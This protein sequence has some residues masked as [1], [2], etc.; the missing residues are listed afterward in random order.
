MGLPEI[1][2]L[3]LLL[4]L[5]CVTYVCYRLYKENK[6]DKWR[7][8]KYEKQVEFFHMQ[9]REQDEAYKEMHQFRHDFKNH[10]ICLNEHVEQDNREKIREC[11]DI[12]LRDLKGG[13]YEH[14]S[15]NLAVD[16]VTGYKL[17]RIKQMEIAFETQ[18]SIPEELPFEETDLCVILGN[19][20]DNAIEASEKIPVAYRKIRFKMEYRPGS[21]FIIIKN[22]FSGNL[23]SDRRGKL[24]TT[25]EEK[26]K[27]GIGIHSVERIARKYQGIVTIETENDSFEL[28]VLLYE[29]SR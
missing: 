6:E 10:L 18:F 20:L 15:G 3:I 7:I 16:A 29:S 9:A 24:L 5:V 28:R 23:S 4:L 1:I 27:H 12:L 25:K 17:K 19:T 14:K 2:S 21:L 22:N 8:V 26:S 13:H 11:M